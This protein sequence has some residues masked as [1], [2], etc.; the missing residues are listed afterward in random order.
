MKPSSIRE[1]RCLL[2]AL[3]VV[4]LVGHRSVLSLLFAVQLWLKGKQIKG[5][6]VS[7]IIIA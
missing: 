2:L 5:E 1:R 6:K 7:K 4:D 3:A